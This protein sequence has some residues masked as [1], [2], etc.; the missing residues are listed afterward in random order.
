MQAL[1][2]ILH[3]PS[4][5]RLVLASYPEYIEFFFMLKQEHDI[6]NQELTVQVHSNLSHKGK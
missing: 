6:T 4:R 2:A 5:M 1:Q 3:I